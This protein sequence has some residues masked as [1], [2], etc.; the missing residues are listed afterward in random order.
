MRQRSVIRV[1]GATAFLVTPIA[2]SAQALSCSIPNQIERPHPE[3]PSAS[4]PQRQLPIGGYT[5]ALTWTPE[6]CHGHAREGRNALECGGGNRFGFALHGLWP[7]GIGRDWPQYC[8]STPLL[9]P[10]TIRANLC[11]TPSA[12]LLQHEWAKHGTCLP[13]LNPDSY[14]KRSTGM[15]AA[16][17]YPDMDALS[18][19]QGLTVGRLAAA[20]ASGN[21]AVP[22][23]AIRVTVNQRGWLDEMWLCLDKGFAYVRC[24]ADSGGSSAATSLKIWRG[25]TRRPGFSPRSSRYPGNAGRDGAE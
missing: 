13:G 21:P 18:R 3:L 25:G 16:L 2:A 19:E 24:R 4:Q 14:F 11:A 22:A 15:Y 12:Q 8:R 23:S 17:R 5:L 9:A 20:I 6:Y 1:M 10:A 7:D